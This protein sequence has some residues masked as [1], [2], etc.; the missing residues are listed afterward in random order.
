ML[1]Q[2]VLYLILSILIVL[3]AHYVHVI[4]VYIDLFYTYVNIKLTTIFS[5][6][7]WAI[8]TR[9]VLALTLIPI[10]IA[11]IPALVYR[12]VKGKQMPYLLHITWLLW[13]IL[14]L[15]KILIH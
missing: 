14:V 10:L 12:A 4:V 8:I 6:H 7:P 2:S 5:N 9:E 13:L 11:A 3:F 1:R 15:S